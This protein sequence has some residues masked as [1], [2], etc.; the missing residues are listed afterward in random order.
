MLFCNQRQVYNFM[1]DN[2]RENT[3]L[4]YDAVRADHKKLIEKKEY[5]V[6]KYS[7]EWILEHIA[8]KYF[9]SSKTIENIVFFRC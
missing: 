2:K 6:Q 8:K 7:N 9:K 5:G 3:Q 1:S 4:L